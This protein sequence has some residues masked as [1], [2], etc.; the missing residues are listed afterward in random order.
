MAEPV[1]D[2][3]WTLP[4]LSRA[5]VQ[6]SKVRFGDEARWQ[7]RVNCGDVLLTDEQLAGFLAMGKAATE[8]R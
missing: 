8:G 6:I 3:T 4:G 2:E 1:T 7:L 5:V